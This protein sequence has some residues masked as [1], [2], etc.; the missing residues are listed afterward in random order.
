VLTDYFRLF[1]HIAGC[2]AYDFLIADISG[3]GIPSRD[4]FVAQL[5]TT[6]VGAFVPQLGT[7]FVP[8][9]AAQGQL[10]SRN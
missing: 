10:S 6:V 2:S 5:G 3:A 4:Y 9:R 8:V 1:G 7:L